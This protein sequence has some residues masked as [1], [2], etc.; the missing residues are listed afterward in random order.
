M[1]APR[2]SVR[3]SEPLAFLAGPLRSVEERQRLEELEAIIAEY[4][5]SVWLPHRE[6]EV[7]DRKAD[8][9][10]V[11]VGN[12]RALCACSL[13]VFVLDT[14]RTGTGIELGYLYALNENGVSTATVLGFVSEGTTSVDLMARF[15]L[16]N[17]S[18]LARG[19][20]ELR[21]MLRRLSSTRTSSPV[22]GIG[23]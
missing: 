14:E 6:I 12:F 4:G 5:W 11:L 7:I 20:G 17:R 19:F 10:S 21:T 13:A 8:D 1:N 18:G 9:L 23:E 3:K 15:C 22:Q 2:E 16:G